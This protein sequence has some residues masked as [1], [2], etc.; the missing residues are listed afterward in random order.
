MRSKLFS[1][2]LCIACLCLTIIFTFTACK[3]TNEKTIYPEVSMNESITSYWDNPVSTPDDLY[4]P[5]TASDTPGETP[6]FGE[7]DEI[8]K[9]EVDTDN[10]GITNDKDDD[11]DGD[12]ILNE[13]DPDMDGD[14]VNN[15]EDSDIDGDDIPNIEDSKPEGPVN[16]DST[17]QSPLVPF[18]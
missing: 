2:P 16:D 7:D 13:D 3:E 4:V 9:P 15:E 17:N 1:M 18:T 5:P 12:G 10:D 6:D 8:T 14:G 11:I